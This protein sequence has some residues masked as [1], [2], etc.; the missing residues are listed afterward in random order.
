MAR[1]T[2]DDCI[3]I[4]PNRFELVI[5]AARRARQLTKGA[6]AT[7]PLEN[8]K[9]TVLALREIGENSVSIKDLY[10]DDSQDVIPEEGE[11]DRV[12]AEARALMDE[13]TNL[14]GVTE[15]SL[16]DVKPA[17][18]LDDLTEEVLE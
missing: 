17:N 12:D 14:S 8:D 7:V 5:L 18:D 16:V 15:E 9:N 11:L 6:E 10:E 3:K 13:E 1:V 2:V 4:V